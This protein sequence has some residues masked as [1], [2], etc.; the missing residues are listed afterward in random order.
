LS[1]VYGIL[2]HDLLGRNLIPAIRQVAIALFTAIHDDQEGMEIMQI[3]NLLHYFC[4]FLSS[5]LKK[6]MQFIAKEKV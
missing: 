6:R 5:G 4:F 1:V 2:E 3:S